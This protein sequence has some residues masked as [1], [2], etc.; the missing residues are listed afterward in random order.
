[1]KEDLKCVLERLHHHESMSFLLA[2][3]FGVR[4][5]ISLRNVPT[6]CIPDYIY[7]YRLLVSKRLN[8]FLVS[9]DFIV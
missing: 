4:S 8:N 2:D 1:M 3:G 5:Y 7:I 9:T 6:I